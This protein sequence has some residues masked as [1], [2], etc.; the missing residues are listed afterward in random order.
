[1]VNQ[2]QTVRVDGK[3]S[4]VECWWG[5]GKHRIYKLQDGRQVSDLHLLVASG[6]AQVVEE[7][8]RNKPMTPFTK[9][10]RL[11]KEDHDFEEQ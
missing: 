7:V 9:F 1:M 11:P 2:G 8:P 6:H 5:A 10:E 4:V 3:E